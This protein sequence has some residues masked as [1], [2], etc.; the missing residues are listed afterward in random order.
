MFVAE[1]ASEN[2]KNRIMHNAYLH[3]ALRSFESCCNNGRGSL[4][5]FGHSLAENDHHVL[6]YIAKG[7]MRRLLVSVY[8]DPDAPV[9]QAIRLN[10]E[11][12]VRMRTASD[13]LPRLD[14]IYFD[15]SARI[16]G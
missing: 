9:N 11:E 10:C 6:R 13:H 2:K 5:V 12:L 14:V 4:T 7:R 3:K 1:G 16:W 8:G 15:A